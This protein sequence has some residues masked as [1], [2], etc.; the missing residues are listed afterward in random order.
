MAW[1][2]FSLYPHKGLTDHKL[3]TRD[4]PWLDGLYLVDIV[5][6]VMP[7]MLSKVLEVQFS[8]RANEADQTYPH[9]VAGLGYLSAYPF[10]LDL[11]CQNFV[12]ITSDQLLPKFI[13][14]H[15]ETPCGRI[16]QKKGIPTEDE[17]SYGT[18]EHP[19]P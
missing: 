17:F 7:C 16:L 8:L 12:H 19:S 2:T 5:T 10:G 1:A 4:F 11:G 9:I 15:Q 6:V 13:Y 3:I 18:N 14:Y